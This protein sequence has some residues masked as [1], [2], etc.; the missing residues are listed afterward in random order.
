MAQKDDTAEEVSALLNREIMAYH[1]ARRRFEEADVVQKKQKKAYDAAR[2]RLWDLLE[3]AGVKTINHDV[4]RIT[5]VNKVVGTVVDREALTE[6]LENHG[7]LE[8]FTRTDFRQAQL[9]GIAKE[10]IEEGDELPEGLDTLTLK[11]ISYTP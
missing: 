1:D 10:A 11:Q 8:A 2:D 9:N 7:L 5:R 4:G 3:S 6:W